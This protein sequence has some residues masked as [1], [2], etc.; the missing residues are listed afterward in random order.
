[1]NDCGI[2]M[3]WREGLMSYWLDSEVRGMSLARLLY[4]PITDI[5]GANVGYAA[6]SGPLSGQALRS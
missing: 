1:M 2:Y 3:R 5:P 6:Q 4:P